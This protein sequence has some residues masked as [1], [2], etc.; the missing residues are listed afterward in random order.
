MKTKLTNDDLFA[1]ILNN[2]FN[3]VEFKANFNEDA[4]NTVRQAI[5]AFANDFPENKQPGFI[6]IEVR[7]SDRAIIG[8]RNG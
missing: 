2:E 4:P 7:D 8:E 1:L 5:C 6:F 3:R